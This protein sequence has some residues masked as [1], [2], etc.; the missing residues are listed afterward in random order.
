MAA[1]WQRTDL[2][3]RL[4]D[5]AAPAL[6]IVGE[7]D[8][9]VPP[10]HGAR[11]ARALPGARCEWVRGGGHIPFEE[12]PRVVNRLILDFFKSQNAGGDDERRRVAQD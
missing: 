6:V 12:A 9:V 5:I 11:I 1:S 3:A 8:T 10:R 4:S 7:N 2:P